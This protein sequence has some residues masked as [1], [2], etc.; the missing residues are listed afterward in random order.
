MTQEPTQALARFAAGLQYEDIPDKA[1]EHCKAL[2][3]D[4][5]ACALA[6]HRGEETHQLAAL[7]AA[8]AQSGEASVIG[9]EKL[10]LA[11][12]TLLNSYLITAVTMCDVHRAT[13]THVTPEVVPP[14]LA[15]AERD[16]STGCDLLVA[17][18]AGCE[19]TTRIG[20]GLDYPA[21]RARGWHG[22]GVLGPFGA[23][24]AVGRLR[25]FDADT[26][27][28]AFGLA[29]SQAAGTFAAWGTPTVKFHQCRGALSGLLAALLAEQNFSA[30]REFLSASDGGLYL[31]YSN[32]GRPELVTA[33]LGRRW[34][35]EQ[36]ALRLWPSA[37]L[38][39]G[40]NTALFDLIAQQKIDPAAIEMVRITLGQTA[41]DMHGKLPRYQGKFEAL[42][43][44]HYTAAA[45]LHDRALTL[46]QFEAARYEDSQLRRFAEEN[47]EI[48]LDPALG[49]AEAVVE[50]G[51]SGGKNLSARCEHPRGSFENPLSREEIEQKF[52][53]YAK[54]G[55]PGARIEQVIEAVN[56][57][58]DLPSARTLMDLL[59][60]SSRRTQDERA[61]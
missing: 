53:T 57:L 59:R 1:R 46:D 5:L 2:L 37:S 48:K 10:S 39:Q 3:L 27:A 55:L 41:F 32:G 8:L 24:A 34:E 31:S 19:V 50:I 43:S 40:T 6:G 14:A 61:A 30:T 7:A 56:R 18:A 20:I 12:A 58:E 35:L 9:G 38:L 52:R 22:P 45:A 47:V 17:L 36:I 26:M 21:F 60:R 54:E 16:G 29:G 42:I 13:M 49:G 15:I 23:A 33:D 11:G 51:M 44:G 4:A 28:R 25:G